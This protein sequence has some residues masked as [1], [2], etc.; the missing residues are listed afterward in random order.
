[1]IL[2]YFAPHVYEIVK[3]CLSILI[4]VVFVNFEKATIA[5]R[6]LRVTAKK[7]AAVRRKDRRQVTLV[8][9]D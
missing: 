9:S 4:F 1:M 3:T 2:H 6:S 7:K 5:F 8:P